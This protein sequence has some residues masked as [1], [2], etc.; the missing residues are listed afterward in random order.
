M[1]KK[2]QKIHISALNSIKKPAISSS[3]VGIIAPA[4]PLETS[5]MREP[6]EVETSLANHLFCHPR[7]KHYG[8]IRHC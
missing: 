5:E 8:P 3:T 6:T 1:V 2:E 4:C 7:G